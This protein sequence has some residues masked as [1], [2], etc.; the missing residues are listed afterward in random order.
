MASEIDT[1]ETRAMCRISLGPIEWMTNSGK[2][3]LTSE[4]S[5]S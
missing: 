5:C 2:A 4:N 1:P 3:A